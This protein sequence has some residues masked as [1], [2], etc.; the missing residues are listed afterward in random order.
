MR[1]LF[2]RY[3]RSFR[4]K[5]LSK[6]SAIVTRYEWGKFFVKN[7]LFYLRLKIPNFVKKIGIN[8]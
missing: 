3:V 8:T 4:W 5:L 7:F 2:L 1:C 6:S